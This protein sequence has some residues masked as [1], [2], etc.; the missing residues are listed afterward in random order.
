M[1]LSPA[2]LFDLFQH[3]AHADQ[4]VVE[5]LPGH[6]EQPEKRRIRD[7]VDHAG[8]GFLSA[9][10]IAM[11]E[12]GQL[13]RDVGLFEIQRRAQ[14]VH[15]LGP[16][17][18]AIEDADTHGVSEGFEKFCFE[19]GELLWHANMQLFAYIKRPPEASQGV[20]S[21]TGAALQKSLW[22]GFGAIPISGVREGASLCRRARGV[23]R[24]A[25]PVRFLPTA[26]CARS[27]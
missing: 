17:P 15:A 18:Q 22:R 14:F 3:L 20:R 25:P 26:H 23:C 11:A 9:H 16:F 7:G 10:N 13:L 12:H 21:Q 8:P 27:E 1:V 6:I 24:R 4:L 2:P 19:V 5:N